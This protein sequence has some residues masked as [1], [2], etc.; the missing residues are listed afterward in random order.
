MRTGM[1][2]AIGLIV[3]VNMMLLVGCGP[4]TKQ[5]NAGSAECI[6][7]EGFESFLSG[8]WESADKK[9]AFTFEPDGRISE[10]RHPVGID[11]VTADGGA[12]KMSAQGK[13]DEFILGQYGAEYKTE[14]RELEVKVQLEYF[15]IFLV[16][17]FFEGETA[18]TI[19]GIVS[20]DGQKWIAKRRGYS[21]LFDG[22][23]PELE[24]VDA[25]TLVFAKIKNQ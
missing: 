20:A 16:D 24:Q 22:P 15:R 7:V 17:R 3:G 2:V 8:T 25:G 21:A 13:E 12:T 4:A 14:T 5:V 9:W 6:R 1:R 23:P 11:I 19:T 18:D 10:L